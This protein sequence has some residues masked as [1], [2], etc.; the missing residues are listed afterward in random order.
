VGL[1]AAVVVALLVFGAC[2]KSSEKFSASG[3]AVD[4][5]TPSTARASGGASSGGGSSTA[6][7]VDSGAPASATQALDAPP[8]E[9]GRKVISTAT[10]RVSTD[11]VATTKARAVSAVDGVG[12]FVYGEQADF[13]SS[14]KVT[15][16]FKVPPDRFDETLTA[17]AA[18]GTL[19][20]QEIKTDDVTQ[21][22][23]DLD[24]RIAAAEA[25]TARLRGLLDKAGTVVEVAAVEGEL[26]K[27]EAELESLR[28]Q[29]RTL[30]RQTDLATVNLTVS[31][32]VATA[33]VQE[34]KDPPGF[35]DGLRGGWAAFVDTARWGS[36]VIGALL[37]FLVVVALIGLALRALIGRRRRRRAAAPTAG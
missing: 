5:A 8:A 13:S 26:A 1:T 29:A 28:G 33:G 7:D 9:T 25:S 23:V 36:A 31:A 32:A 27:R 37:P 16:T 4:S 11:D 34:A 24:A 2:S 18:L 12:G 22:V 15:L 21:K 35:A 14:A 30:A 20:S 17:L 10:L 6:A 19:Q 3:A